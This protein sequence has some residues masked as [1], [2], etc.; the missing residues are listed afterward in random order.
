MKILLAIILAAACLALSAQG[1]N[2]VISSCISRVEADSI[3]STLTRLQDFG[4]RYMLVDN[5]REIASWIRERFLSYGYSD[6][7]LDSF[8]ITYSDSAYWQYNVVCTL[9]GAGAPDE[10]CVVGGHYDSYSTDDPYTLAPG[11]DDNGSAVAATLEMARVIRLAGFQ[12]ECTIRFLLF[13]AE[14]LGLY[15]SWHQSQKSLE[16]GEDI[17]LMFDIDM[18]AFNPDS[19]TDVYLFRYPGTESAYELASGA[20]LN[21]TG[22]SVTPG[23]VDFQ[24][25]SDSYPYWQNGFPVTWAFECEFNTFYHSPADVVSNCNISYCAEIVQ[26]TLA[27]VMEL[28]FLPFPVGVA[29]HSSPDN[30]S[31]HWKPTANTHAA[32]YNVYRSENDSTGF[33]RVN[34]SLLADTFYIDHAAQSGRNYY[35]HATLVN[36]SL[37]ES[38]PSLT[39]HGARFAFGDTLLVVA[40]M[41][42]TQV[43]P[44]SIRQFYASVLDSIPFRWFDMN[45]EQALN[46]AT[47]SQYRNMLWVVNSL[48]YDMITPQLEGDLHSFFENHGNLMFAGF[49]FS[50]FMLGNIGYPMKYPENSIGALYF[51]TDSV[52]KTINSYM[53]RAYPD[54][55]GYDTLWVDPDKIMKPGHPGELYNIEVFTPAPGGDP[56]YRFDSRYDPGTTQGCQQGKITGME[57]MGDAFKTILLSFPLYYLDTADARRLMNYVMKNKFVNP[58]GM[59]GTKETTGISLK[60]RPNPCSGRVHI[61]AVNVPGETP[62]LVTL[63]NMQGQKV[64]SG[65]ISGGKGD[66]DLPLPSGL[67]VL[68]IIS[69]VS[70]ASGLIIIQ[71]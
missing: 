50:R 37:Q 52:F 18:I 56:V 26:G 57:Y 6:V 71:K 39:V 54:K 34:T 70:I 48:D 23:P 65:K 20:F 12:P 1:P 38:V 9:A 69:G 45:Q 30:I 2:P 8:P 22:L 27:S 17:R 5:R 35:Y 15:G 19:L 14:E 32:G 25:R 61:E 46:L 24:H 13:A 47:L 68:K 31:V 63:N 29:A 64:F 44:D 7:K 3:R 49:S 43:T 42:G 67:Y 33:T 53:Y 41:K 60:I 59:P 16:E 10:V 28:Q 58:L 21:Y 40:C 36:D 11:V 66:L 55:A 51:K 4:T 62:C